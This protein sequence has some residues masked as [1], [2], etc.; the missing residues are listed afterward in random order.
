METKEEL[1]ATLKANGDEWTSEKILE[2]ELESGFALTK[3]KLIQNIPADYFRRKQSELLILIHEH[4]TTLKKFGN[5][6]SRN[7]GMITENH[8]LSKIWLDLCN[9][10]IMEGYGI[11]QLLILN[12]PEPDDEDLTNSNLI[13]NFLDDLDNQIQRSPSHIDMVLL[14]CHKQNEFLDLDIKI[15]N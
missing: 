15:N 13:I 6:V 2:K 9:A 5:T 8:L 4:T 10:F 12:K 1:I 3:Q 7:Q 11:S 14:I